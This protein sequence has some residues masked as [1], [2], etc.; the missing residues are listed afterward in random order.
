VE[1]KR[2]SEVALFAGAVLE[3]AKK[4]SLNVPVNQ[5]LYD[6]IMAIE[7]RY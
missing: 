1:A 7:A 2:F 4:H 5:M 6:N 3:L